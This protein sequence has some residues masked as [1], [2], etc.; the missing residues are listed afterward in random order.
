MYDVNIGDWVGA[1][2]S[3]VFYVGYV[4]NLGSYVAY[5][6]VTHPANHAGKEVRPIYANVE[7]F[8]PDFIAQADLSA[9]VDVA[10]DAGD[11]EWFTELCER[12][13]AA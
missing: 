11:R 2:V 1:T 3:G 9:L 10:L 6:S 7:R 8:D 12:R 13:V 5:V 4:T